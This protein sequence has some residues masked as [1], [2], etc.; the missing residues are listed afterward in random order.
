M[1]PHSQLPLSSERK[2]S[3]KRKLRILYHCIARKVSQ[4]GVSAVKWARVNLELQGTDVETNVSYGLDSHNYFNVDTLDFSFLMG[5][6]TNI[7]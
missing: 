6:V 4:I 1:V 2:F 5:V 3:T 7:F